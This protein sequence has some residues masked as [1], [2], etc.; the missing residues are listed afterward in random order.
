[1]IAGK[2]RASATIFFFSVAR[3]DGSFSGSG[4]FG[5]TTK[6]YRG[7]FGKNGENLRTLQKASGLRIGPIFYFF[8]TFFFY[9]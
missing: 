6:R 4:I 2:R 1:M 3:Q 7:W 5:F 8:V 9:F